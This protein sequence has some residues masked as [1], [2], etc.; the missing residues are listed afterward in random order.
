M[1]QDSYSCH[2]AITHA[3][4]TLSHTDTHAH[5]CMLTRESFTTEE[6]LLKLFTIL[7]FYTFQLLLEPFL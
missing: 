1:P 4:L 5:T 7:N 6:N 3:S 2:H